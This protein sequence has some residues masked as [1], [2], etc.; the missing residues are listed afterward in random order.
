MGI[1]SKPATDDSPAIFASAPNDREPPMGIFSK[2]ATDDSPAIFASAPNDKEPPMGIFSKPA[3][4]DYPLF[5][6]P[7][8][9]EADPSFLI[10]LNVFNITEEKV[11]SLQ[12]SYKSNQ[13]YIR[14]LQEDAGALDF[15][16]PI[17]VNK[18][19]IAS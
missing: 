5:S 10:Y 7:L 4:D 18:H 12:S 16:A 3:T 8:H 1:F 13:E 6:P 9:T 11:D 17:N 15:I 14:Q 19:R 2:P